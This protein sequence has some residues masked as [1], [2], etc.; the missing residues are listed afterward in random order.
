[1]YHIFRCWLL[2]ALPICAS[3]QNI[4]TARLFKQD[5]AAVV[6]IISQKSGSPV[7]Q[8]TGIL[9]SK[10]GTIVSA[11]HI[12]EGADSA[13]VKLR[14]GDVYDSVSVVAFDPRRDLIVLKISGFDLPTLPLGNSN[15]AKEGDPVAMISNPKG[16]EGSITQGIISAVREIGDLGFKVI[17]TTAAASPGSSGGAILNASGELIGILSFKV[18]GGENLN[19]GIPVNYARGMLD[20]RESFPIAQL[21]SRIAEVPLKAASQLQT[22]KPSDISGDWKSLTSGATR[23]VRLEEG[24]AYVE[25]VVTEEQSKLGIFQLCDLTAREGRYEGTCRYQFVTRWYDKRHYQWR[26]RAC[27]SQRQMEFTKY[28]P[29]RIEGRAEEKGRGEKWSGKD[30]SDCGE[31]FPLKWEDFVW[32]RP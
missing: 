8:G 32:I 27:Q 2:V 30:N 18:V 17:Q 22:A 21:E 26:T 12:L 1:M 24:H 10:D 15:E 7:G 9:V 16:L 28:S 13:V 23:R 6:L 25:R 14:N 5:S 11:L 4:D 20:S 29:S 19:F 31:R 3:L